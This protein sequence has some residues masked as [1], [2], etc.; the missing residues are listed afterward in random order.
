M[1]NLWNIIGA[2]A[3]ALA[4]A[5]TLFV[6]Y[7]GRADQEKAVRVDLLARSKIVDEKLPRPGRSIELLYNGRK[8][9]NYE[10]LQ[11]RITNTGRQPIRK[12]DYESPITLDFSNISEI[13]SVDQ[14]GSSPD[15]LKVGIQLSGHSAQLSQ[16]LLNP[17]D[18]FN[19]EVGVV[20][21]S[22]K[23][24][25]VEPKGRIAGVKH[26]QYVLTVEM[27][28]ARDT[29][30]AIFGKTMPFLGILFLLMLIPMI[31]ELFMFIR[32]K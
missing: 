29:V 24:T 23:V 22:G 21:I 8:I 7:Q 30:T 2:V 9:P 19:L 17:T 11:F 32:H 31:R 13:L 28:E 14:T 10:V 12:A 15:E 5:V 18:W 20:P 26:I 3:G 25:Y 1:K 16:E 4:V 27:P 6:F